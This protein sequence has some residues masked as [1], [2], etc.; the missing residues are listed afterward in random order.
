M[1]Q[2]PDTTY[3]QREEYS[4]NIR[5]ILEV[6]FEISMSLGIR[7]LLLQV[8]NSF[9]SADW[10]QSTT[11]WTVTVIFAV[12]FAEFFSIRFKKTSSSN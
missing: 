5:K 12:I 4:M 8:G 11:L 2:T 3:T 7:A 6:V 1:P 10:S 9:F